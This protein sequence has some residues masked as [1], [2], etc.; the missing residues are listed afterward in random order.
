MVYRSRK[1]VVYRALQLYDKLARRVEGSS[2]KVIR[3]GSSRVRKNALGQECGIGR[4]ANKERLAIAAQLKEV[5]A[6][7]TI[8]MT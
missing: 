4:G 2:R 7:A 3:R 1:G 6:Q 8:S 5:H